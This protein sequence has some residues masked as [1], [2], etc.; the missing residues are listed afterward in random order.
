[1]SSSL[2]T[3]PTLK[4][5]SQASIFVSFLLLVVSFSYKQYIVLTTSY[6]FLFLGMSLIVLEVFNGNNSKTKTNLLISFI[7]IFSILAFNIYILIMYK[8]KIESNDVSP[9]YY[10]LT[11]ASK[12]LLIAIMSLLISSFYYPYTNLKVSIMLLLV[13]ISVIINIIEVVILKDFTTDG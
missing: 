9:S 6:A 4:N 2:Q 1:M 8:D 3:L 13:S 11:N 12:V 5:T 7:M 10:S